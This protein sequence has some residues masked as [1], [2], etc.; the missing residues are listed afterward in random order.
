MLRWLSEA[1]RKFALLHQQ[2]D[3][4]PL[5]GSHVRTA[6]SAGTLGPNLHSQISSYASITP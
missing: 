4:F 3:P 5:S 1:S 2:I 6:E